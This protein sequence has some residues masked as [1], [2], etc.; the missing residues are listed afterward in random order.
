MAF[1]TFYDV[2]HLRVLRY[3]VVRTGSAAVAADLCSETY[4]LALEGLERY[5]PE[6]GEGGAWLLGIARHV[7]Q[8]F[9]RSET[10]STRARARM[11]LSVEPREQAELERIEA[12]VDFRPMVG[13]LTAALHTLS[14]P[15]R[16]AGSAA[17]RR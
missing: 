4:A 16:E 14:V 2:T 15:V 5:R 8:Q 6:L 10:A 17:D 1:G 9:V 3:F 12:L 7:H 11:G 13:R